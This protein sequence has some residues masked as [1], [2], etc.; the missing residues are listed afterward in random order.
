MFFDAEE[1]LRL[2]IRT[3]ALRAGKSATELIEETLKR[4]F[5]KELDEA[6]RVLQA[7]KRK[8]GKE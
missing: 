8:D 2:A 6:R 7:R 1:D 3:A 4:E 5:A